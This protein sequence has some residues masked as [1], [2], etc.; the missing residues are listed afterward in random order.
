MNILKVY[1]DRKTAMYYMKDFTRVN[2]GSKCWTTD[3]RVTLFN[4]VEVYFGYIQREQDLNRYQGRKYQILEIYTTL[5]AESE[6]YLMS[7]VRE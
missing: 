2:P 4:G 5:S 6:S 3:C 1:C 7:T